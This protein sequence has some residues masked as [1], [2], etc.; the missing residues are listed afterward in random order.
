MASGQV[1]IIQHRDVL[2]EVFEWTENFICP[3]PNF[4]NDEE[5][6]KMPEHKE[7]VPDYVCEHTE[8]LPSHQEGC[9]NPYDEGPHLLEEGQEQELEIKRYNSLV[10]PAG[11]VMTTTTTTPQRRFVES[12]GEEEDFIDY[13]FEHVESFV[14]VDSDMKETLGNAPQAGIEVDRRLTEMAKK[15]GEA[16]IYID[17][18]D[19]IQVTQPSKIQVIQAEE[20]LQPSNSQPIFYH[21]K[22]E[23]YES[24]KG[25]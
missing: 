17:Q 14:C 9:E 20:N 8:S 24:I 12:I 16:F 21:S 22:Q 25:N 19:K 15:R 4:K 11:Q 1:A 6:R 18:E 3:T 13:V 5:L 10:A 23:G 2:D 7:D